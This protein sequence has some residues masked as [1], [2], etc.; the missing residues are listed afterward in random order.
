MALSSEELKRIHLNK[1]ATINRKYYGADE[2]VYLGTS[3]G[4]LRLLD[5]AELSVFKPTIDLN[6]KNI[7]QAIE[8]LTTLLIKSKTKQIEVDFGNIAI[9]EKSFT[10]AD[11]DV[12]SN[13][14]IIAQLAYEAPTGKDLDEIEMDY[15]NIRCSTQDGLLTMFITS[16]DGSYLHDKFKINYTLI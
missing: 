1:L 9:P 12:K 2:N 7:Q 15:L 5:K 8:E 13:K 10:I 16:N 11:G 14:K 3:E 6:S 4:R